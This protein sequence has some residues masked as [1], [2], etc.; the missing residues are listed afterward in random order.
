MNLAILPPK[1]V[2]YFLIFCLVGFLNFIH[3]IL[4][5]LIDEVDQV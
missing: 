3:N 1:F 5:L 2:T 4:S